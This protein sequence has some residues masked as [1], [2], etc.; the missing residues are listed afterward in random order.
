MISHRTSV[1]RF[2]YSFTP[3][4]VMT[5]LA[6]FA[7]VLFISLGCWQVARSHEKRD[8]L[9]REAL[10]SIKAPRLFQA[11]SLQPV[12]YEQLKVSGVF[13]P[14]IFLLDNQY[15][16]H[17]M[18]FDV[19]TPL[20]LDQDHVLLVDRGFIPLLGTRADL[21]NVPIPSGLIHMSGR[22]YF[23]SKKNWVLGEGIEQ[24]KKDLL[25]LETIDRDM[26]SKFL[27]KSVYPFIMRLNVHEPYGYHRA[28]ATVSMP[29][30]RHLGYA[31]QWFAMA[32]AVL[33]LFI[34]LNLKKR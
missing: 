1:S 20:A 7:M 9:Q 18:G 17:Q 25:I 11:K 33:V 26:L 5:L 10:L 21:P 24:R 34:V 15:L 30:V 3:T 8:M 22:A 28:W 32:G 16:D 27:H 4:L 19:L 29:P 12:Q 2:N 14:Y 31:V 23:P 13:L 6:C